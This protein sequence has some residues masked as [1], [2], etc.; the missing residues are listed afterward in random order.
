MLL[1]V[2]GL[3]L[4]VVASCKRAAESSAGGAESGTPGG[5]AVVAT[6]SA[7][8]EQV[9]PQPVQLPSP[10]AP[11]PQTSAKPSTREKASDPKKVACLERRLPKQFSRE[12]YAEVD[13]AFRAC[14]PGKPAELFDSGVGGMRFGRETRTGLELEVRVYCADVCPDYTHV[15]IAYVGVKS[16]DECLCLQGEPLLTP[17]WSGYAGC[18]PAR[19]ERPNHF[20]AG[21]DFTLRL[22]GRDPSVRVFG[23]VI[24]SEM[25]VVGLDQGAEIL[26]MG[27]RSITAGDELDVRA[28]LERMPRH[29]PGSL[30]VR[31]NH[32][33]AGR[34]LIREIHYASRKTMEQLASQLTDFARNSGEPTYCKDG[35]NLF[36]DRKQMCAQTGSWA[37]LVKTIELEAARGQIAVELPL[38]R[39]ADAC[40]KVTELPSVIG[41]DR[42]TERLEL[43]YIG[44]LR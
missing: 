12:R 9:L 38:A 30:T 42:G 39:S 19:H 15:S 4:L 35:P 11:R 29:P 7:E 40:R 43:R 27:D 37:G 36:V 28:A 21:R 10:P 41:V 16:L 26:G 44:W 33:G 5:S 31:I 1:R 8:P 2:L 22:V 18:A 17:G 34:E 13:A 24:G 23:G 6:R 32:G 14:F 20:V 25:E 3:S